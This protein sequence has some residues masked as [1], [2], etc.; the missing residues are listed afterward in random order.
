[1]DF[2]ILNFTF[3]TWEIFSLAWFTGILVQLDELDLCQNFL[4]G[5]YGET[6]LCRN[7]HK[8]LLI[9]VGVITLKESKNG[10]ERFI[11]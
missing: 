6:D 10:Y 4:K 1:M 8:D 9:D 7:F 2:Y 5:P 11:L 3:P